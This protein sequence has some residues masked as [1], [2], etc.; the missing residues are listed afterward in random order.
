MGKEFNIK[1]Y[2]EP[3]IHILIFGSFLTLI[4]LYTRT[5]GPFRKENGSI[6]YPI[7]FGAA[8]N[9]FLFYFNAFYLIPHFISRD[10]YRKYIFWLL[11][12]HVSLIM[13]NSLVDHF[14]FIAIYSTDKEPFWAEILINF[15]SKTFILALSLGYGF[16][17]IMIRK[18][19]ARQQLI[20]D[21]LNAELKILKA[22]IDPHF[23]FNTLNMAYASGIKSGDTNTANII[24]KLAVLMRYVI[25]ETNGDKVPLEKDIN[26]IE[27][28][29]S[30][31]LQR[32]SADISGN[33]KYHIKGD[34]QDYQIAPMILIP[35]IENVFKHG[36]RLDKKSGIEINLILQSG[37]LIL[38][39]RNTL[40]N[41]N[42][43]NNK[44]NSG[45]GLENVKKRLEII[46]PD[47]HKLEIETI[48]DIY[49]SRLELKL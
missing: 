41:S 40:K 47:R 8:V 13:L 20:E 48:N 17:K 1:K 5:L 7:L 30:L 14:F 22:Q 10:K 23:L 25:Y 4:I 49:H 44:S 15:E 33:I 18:E 2:I 46:Y 36:I 29:I 9:A 12:F 19:K 43:A 21:K 39:T 24:E 34:W 37:L 45:I 28:Y 16:A 6:Y 27:N 32:L 3:A 42:E 26:Y 35:F 31:Q 11:A 38:E